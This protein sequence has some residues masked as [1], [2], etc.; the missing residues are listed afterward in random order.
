MAER[1]DNP[2]YQP[3]MGGFDRPGICGAKRS[4]EAASTVQ[5]RTRQERRHVFEDDRNMLKTGRNREIYL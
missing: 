5:Q 4:L 1:V 3:T 2:A